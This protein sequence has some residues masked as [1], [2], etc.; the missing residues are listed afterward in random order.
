MPHFAPLSRVLIFSGLMT[1][2]PQAKVARGVTFALASSL[3][4]TTLPSSVLVVSHYLQFSKRGC[5]FCG[6]LTPVSAHCYT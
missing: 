5:G 1:S 3:A 6:I 4:S 2:H